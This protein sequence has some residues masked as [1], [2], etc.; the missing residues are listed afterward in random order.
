MFTG[1][2]E[3]CVA[4]L[5]FETRAEGARLVLA[6]PA[7]WDVQNGQSIA[8]CGTCLTVVDLSAGP[9]GGQMGFDLSAET[10]DRTWFSELAPGRS[11]N[12][13]RALRLG[14]RLDGHMVAG[15]VDGVGRIVAIDDV[16]DGGRVF[17]FELPPEHARYLVEKG[18][19]TIDGISL[20]V[21]AP[22]DARFSVAIIPLTLE[23]TNL[24]DAE[25]GQAVN[26]EVDRV[27]KWVARMLAP[28]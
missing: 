10:L 18:S 2:I 14:D 4:V 13:E 23:L 1:I 9:G 16:D 5:A 11:V 24:G 20:T 21:V 22:R 25:V 26:F 27:G 17:H 19:V 8:I 12:L 3:V 15:H 6:A 28:R 7:G